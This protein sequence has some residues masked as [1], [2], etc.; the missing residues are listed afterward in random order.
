VS[1]R[2]AS[3]REAAVVA[4]AAGRTFGLPQVPE[5][6]ES[7][8]D[9]ARV[10]FGAAACSLAEVDVE[11]SELVYRASVGAGAEDTVGLRLPLGHGIAGYAAASG[12]VVAVDDVT[13]DPRFARDVA[14]QTG[15]VPRSV[16]AAP[17]TSG[18]DVLGV[19]SVLDRTQPGGAAALDLAARCARA[20]RGALVL[21]AATRSIGT[22]AFDALA[23]DLDPERPDVAG[24]LH[25]VARGDHAADA[26][27]T[28]IVEAL[29]ATRRLGPAERAAAAS[30]LEEFVTYASARRSRR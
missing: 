9:V 28:R 17:V 1:P 26:E 21:G 23:A 3:L 20:V 8:L 4:S 12:E 16:L 19:F 5:L 29:A 30:I 6:V 13:R 27:T 7:V 15:F 22:A 14:E 25:A 24:T 11:T 2:R 18:E 10:A